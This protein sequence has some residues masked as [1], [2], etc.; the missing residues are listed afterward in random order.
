LLA[1]FA[2][3]AGSKLRSRRAYAD[4]RA[5]VGALTRPA[6]AQILAPMVVAAELAAVASLAAS[7]TRPAG[8]ALAAILLLA[9]SAAMLRAVARRIAVPCRC[10]GRAAILSRSHVWRN[11]ALLIVVCLG[12]F[13]QPRDMTAHG[14]AQTLAGVAT[15]L[16]A[17][18]FIASWDAV[19][20]LFSTSPPQT[21]RARH[22]NAAGT[23]T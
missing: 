7:W 10:F 20:F 22:P 1:T 3:S 11:V 21:A 6:L 4:F 12:A 18:G 17:A 8:L 5:S 23:A 16:A 9:F 15:G 19:A 13:W 2:M 14:S